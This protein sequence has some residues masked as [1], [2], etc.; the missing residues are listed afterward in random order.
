MEKTTVYLTKDLQK[1]LKRA[2]K[3]S[4]RS[5]ANVIREA[6]ESYLIHQPPRVPRSLGA[7]DLNLP[8]G[9]NSS[10]VKSWL[11]QKWM[12]DLQ[13]KRSGSRRD[14]SAEPVEK[15]S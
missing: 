8:P 3:D 15:S 9:V 11:R 2:A 5:E 12:D 4:G 10:N 14:T 1:K 13:A 7:I 6:L